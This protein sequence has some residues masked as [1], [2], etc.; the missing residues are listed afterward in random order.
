M[1]LLVETNNPSQKVLTHKKSFLV[2]AFV[3]SSVTSIESMA[4]SQSFSSNS[5]ANFFNITS[6]QKD[7]VFGATSEPVKQ[8]LLGK[9]KSVF[10]RSTE[11]P[12][13]SKQKRL[14]TVRLSGV[15]PKQSTSVQGNLKQVQQVVNYANSTLLTE[16]TPPEVVFASFD[17]KKDVTSASIRA[18]EMNLGKKEPNYVGLSYIKAFLK[19]SAQKEAVPIIT[20]EYFHLILNQAIAD[21]APEFMSRMKNSLTD[22]HAER[23]EHKDSELKLRASS[24]KGQAENARFLVTNLKDLKEWGFSR[25]RVKILKNWLKI[26]NR[27]DLF[28]NIE[29]SEQNVDEMI[30]LF[31]K[32]RSDALIQAQKFEKLR[33]NFEFQ[34]S[35]EQSA[36]DTLQLTHINSFYS[37]AIHELFADLGAILLTGDPS[38]LAK[39]L[40]SPHRDFNRALTLEEASKEYFQSTE[41]QRAYALKRA[42]EKATNQP[43]PTSEEIL[44]TLEQL[45]SLHAIHPFFFYHRSLL[46]R[47]YFS[48]APKQQW[49]KM[50]KALADAFAK[51]I[52]NNPEEIYDMVRVNGAMVVNFDRSSQHLED[53]IRGALPGR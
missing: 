40:N 37:L 24:L 52:V 9:L 25:E 47:E 51:E 18:Y 27:D 44:Q 23:M 6:T 14:T 30:E 33:A 26:I 20:H 19:G 35:T 28:A 38:V 7:A 5:C 22:S 34:K 21:L 49:P 41:Q 13:S 3:V 8:I 15:Q 11:I 50:M 36:E 32:F 17:E 4:G 45:Q 29:F 16:F 2:F 53:V 10:G 46:W 39:Q 43:P 1:N 42:V 31:E 48:K 12:D